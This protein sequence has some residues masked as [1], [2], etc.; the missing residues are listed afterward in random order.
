MAIFRYNKIL[1]RILTPMRSVLWVLL[2]QLD[3]PMGDTY[4][5]EPGSG[6]LVEVRS[7]PVKMG[8]E[9]VAVV[10]RDSPIS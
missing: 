5:S 9:A 8:P 2:Y 10:E 7:C 3:L 6:L 1:N 4:W